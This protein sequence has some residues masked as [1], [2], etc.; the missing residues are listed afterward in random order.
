LRLRALASGPQRSTFKR[1]SV[2]KKLISGV[3]GVVVAYAIWQGQDG[4]PQSAPP[5]QAVAAP[6]VQTPA[7]ARSATPLHSDTL[8][9]AIAAHAHDVHVEGEGV[10]TKL[11][12]ED[13]SGSR[14]QRFVIRT[15]NGRSLLVAYNLDIAPRIVGLKPGGPIGFAGEYVW[16]DRGGL[17]H[18]TH[19]D[20]AH[21]HAD[22]YIRYD[23]HLYR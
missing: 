11:L 14:H 1:N 21:R 4:Q 12:R 20:P 8:E 22:G 23:G 5:Q 9:R 15:R 17:I 3:A 18:W 13:T 10:V 19:R 16:N 2:L 7:P 6:R